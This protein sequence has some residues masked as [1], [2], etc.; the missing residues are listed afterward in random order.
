[1]GSFRK[2]VRSTLIAVY[3]LI[4]VGGVVRSTGSGM[5]CPDWPRCFG[6]WTPPTSVDQLPANYKEI[7][8]D[9]RHKKNERFAKYLTAF[10]FDETASKIL[11]DESIKEE[12]D[13]NPVKTWI[14]YVNRIVGVIIGFLIFLV[15]VFSWRHR[16]SNLRITLIS[17]LTFVLVGFQGWIG[18]VVV[19]TNLTPWTI[20]VHMFLAMVIVALLIYLLHQVRNQEVSLTL[21]TSGVRILII[22]CMMVL[23]VQILF[24]T[25]VREG[26]DRVSQAVLERNNWISAIGFDFILHRAFSWVVLV[27]NV[28]LLV[29]LWKMQGTNRFALTVFILILGTILT[30]AGMAWFGVPPFLQPVH[31]TLATLTFGLQF[32]LILRLNS[33][34][35]T[36]I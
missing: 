13:F 20:T 5:G 10:G 8:A 16:K 35:K 36:A 1:M 12:G 9:Y 21:T 28:L 25:Q 14:E 22:V 27:L 24:G 2:L 15:F 26:V 3:V 6:N 29:K 31:L 17:F 33:K 7:Y 23:L 4:L 11:N 32:L 19:S 30:G 34:S 18:S